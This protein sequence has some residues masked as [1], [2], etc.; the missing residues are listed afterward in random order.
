MKCTYN[1]PSQS[2]ISTERNIASDSQMI[3]LDNMRDGLEA[4]LELGNLRPTR[5]SD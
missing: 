3:K 5:V 4:L 2:D 1:G